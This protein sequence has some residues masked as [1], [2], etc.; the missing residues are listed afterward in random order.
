[1]EELLRRAEVYHYVRR[2]RRRNDFRMCLENILGESVCI[3]SPELNV[4]GT[5]AV[6]FPSGKIPVSSWERYG[7]EVQGTGLA[8]VP[9]HA[10]PESVRL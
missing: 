9:P 6:V 7:A 2:D 5:E 4:L 10:A 8:G 1:M 3:D